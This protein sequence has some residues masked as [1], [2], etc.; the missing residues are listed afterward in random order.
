MSSTLAASRPAA[1]ILSCSAGVLMVTVIGRAD[2]VSNR[3]SWYK[4]R[5]FLTTPHACRHSRLGVQRHH[6]ELRPQAAGFKWRRRISDWDTRRLN[7]TRSI[8]DQRVYATNAGSGRPFRTPDPL[9]E[10]QDGSVHLRR[11]KPDPPHQSC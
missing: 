7:P 2:F 9:L 11:T 6:M 5:L 1:R 4:A 3:C 8:Y 10:P